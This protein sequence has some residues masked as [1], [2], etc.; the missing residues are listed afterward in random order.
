MRHERHRKTRQY[1]LPH[2]SKYDI[3]EV[4][5]F[6][7]IDIRSCLQILVKTRKHDTSYYK[8]PLKIRKEKVS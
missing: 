7:P 3:Y 8:V 4:K 1:C 2:K 5:Y 6:L